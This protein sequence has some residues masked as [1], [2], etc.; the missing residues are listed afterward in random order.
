MNTSNGTLAPC[1]IAI[2]GAGLMGRMLAVSLTQ[3]NLSEQYAV[4]LFDQDSQHGHDS[5]AYLAAAML[6]PLA[7]STE[8]SKNIMHMGEHSLNLWPIFLNTLEAPVFFQQQGSVILSHNQDH[9]YLLD[10]QR[11]LKRHDSLNVKPLNKSALE[12][13]EPGLAGQSKLFMNALYLPNEG[14]LDNRELL[15]S[16]ALT[17]KK[18]KIAW[19]HNTSVESHG[20]QVTFSRQ[21]KHFDWVIDCRGLGANTVNPNLRGVRG[22]VIR[23]HAPQVDISRPVRLMH[24]R[25]PIY[26]APK[27]NHHFVIGATQTESEDRRQPTI[28]SVLELLSSCYSL[29]KGFAEAEV[30]E[31]Q[32]GLRPALPD[33]EPKITVN[34]QAIQV[35]GLFRHGYLLAP[36]LVEQCLSVI[37]QAQATLKFKQSFKNSEGLPNIKRCSLQKI[38]PTVQIPYFKDLVETIHA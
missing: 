24:P 20:N 2:L 4:T 28:R 7:E 33:N 11:R 22:E 1:R 10:F 29:H 13:L 8:A 27:A 5:A 23:V 18:R 26:I 25:Y 3:K 16:L 14:Q 15:S 17:L 36:T 9:A 6:A 19:F 31:I 38:Q 34:G 21:S 30:L 37:Q 12:K 32:A 35:N